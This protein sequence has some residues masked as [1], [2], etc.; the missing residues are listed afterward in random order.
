MQEK[1]YKK[2]TKC[3]KQV[4]DHGLSKYRTCNSNDLCT[5]PGWPT[6]CKKHCEM[7]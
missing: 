6:L 4:F 7:M 2:K 5:H 3:Q 1:P